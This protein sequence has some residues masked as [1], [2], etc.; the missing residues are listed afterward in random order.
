MEEEAERGRNRNE[1]LPELLRH[2]GPDDALD[3]RADIGVEI[4][5]ELREWNRKS[6]EE[7]AEE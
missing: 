1:S 2:G 7:K 6:G 4:S 3:V 5:P